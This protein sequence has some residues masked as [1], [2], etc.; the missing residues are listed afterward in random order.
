ML[1]GRH[2]PVLSTGQPSSPPIGSCYQMAVTAAWP[3]VLYVLLKTRSQERVPFSIPKL[4]LEPLVAVLMDIADKP[5]CTPHLMRHAVCCAFLASL[6][7]GFGGCIDGPVITAC[8][9][10]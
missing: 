5:P 4:L 1:L 6:C 9:P 7:P 8:S 3:C 2:K 10:L